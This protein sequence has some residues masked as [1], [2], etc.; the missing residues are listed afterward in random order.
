MVHEQPPLTR[1]SASRAVDVRRLPAGTTCATITTGGAYTAGATVAAAGST[2]A[3]AALPARCGR[4]TGVG[5]ARRTAVTL[6][7]AP[8]GN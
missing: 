6:E 1:C 8:G 2:T 5:N 4:A 3:G 7:L